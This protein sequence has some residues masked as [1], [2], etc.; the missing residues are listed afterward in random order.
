MY[1][2]ILSSMLVIGAATAAAA[3]SLPHGFKQDTPPVPGQIIQTPREKLRLAP[4]LFNET[5]A[6]DLGLPSSGPKGLVQE[7]SNEDKYAPSADGDDFIR[8]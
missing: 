8:R 3:Q 6:P 1:R 4:S 5:P 7:S 2:L